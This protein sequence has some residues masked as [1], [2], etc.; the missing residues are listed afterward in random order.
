[1]GQYTTFS[2][3][4]DLRNPSASMGAC[5]HGQGPLSPPF[6][7]APTRRLQTHVAYVLMYD[8]GLLQV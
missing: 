5:P 2:T 6:S 1:M 7:D 3:K 4:R 8:C